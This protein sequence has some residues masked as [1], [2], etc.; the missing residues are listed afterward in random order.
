MSLREENW[1]YKTSLTPPRFIE[2]PVLSHESER[3]CI[4]VNQKRKCQIYCARRISGITFIKYAP[5]RKIGKAKNLKLWE[6]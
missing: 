6:Q 3:L 5:K 2:V 4:S 1:V